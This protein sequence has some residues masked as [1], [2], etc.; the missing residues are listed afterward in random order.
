MKVRLG[1]VSNSSSSSFICPVCEDAQEDYDG[2]NTVYCDGCGNTFCNGC[3]EAEKVVRYGD[4]IACN[5]CKADAGKEYCPCNDITKRNS[6]EKY[7]IQEGDECPDGISPSEYGEGKLE[8]CPICNLE[9]IQ[10]DDMLKFIMKNLQI[11]DKIVKDDI[12]RTFKSYKEFQKFIK[13]KK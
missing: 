4:N 12:K 2:E 9:K 1:F 5:E 3:I 7:N 11:T 8:N 10:A 6:I 13:A